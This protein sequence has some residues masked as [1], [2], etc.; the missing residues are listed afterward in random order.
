MYV[1]IPRGCRDGVKH[2]HYLGEKKEEKERDMIVTSC[3]GNFFSFFFTLLEIIHFVLLC[4]KILV[5]KRCEMWGVQQ[6]D[7]TVVYTQ[8]LYLEIRSDA[9]VKYLFVCV[10]VSFFFWHVC[11]SRPSHNSRIGRSEP[12][13]I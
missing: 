7:L 4:F 1:W 12:V 6:I 3:I 9:C 8:K 11:L 13:P 10:F 2:S 5:L